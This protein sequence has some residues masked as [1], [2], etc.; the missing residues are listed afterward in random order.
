MGVKESLGSIPLVETLNI[1][2][3]GEASELWI[4]L[5]SSFPLISIPSTFPQM[6]LICCG[7]DYNMWKSAS[8]SK[9][10]GP[11]LRKFAKRDQ[12]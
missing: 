7:W 3:I 1:L 12:V 9:L 11:K 6:M 8:Y 2:F 10:L 5:F 4:D